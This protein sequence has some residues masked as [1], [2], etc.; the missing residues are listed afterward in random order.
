MI[1]LVRDFRL[2]PVVLL[3]SIALLT[4]KTFGL[5]LDGG[6]ILDTPV[7]DGTTLI[8][9]DTDSNDIVGSIDADKR[10]QP[11]VPSTPPVTAPLMPTPAAVPPPRHS[12]AQEM[13][14]YP[15]VTGS[16]GATKKE[17]PAPEKPK[18]GANNP[19]K[20]PPPKETNVLESR[21]ASPAER[22]ILER[23]Q[24]RRKDLEA[25]AREL[26]MRETLIK[27]AEKRLDSK[28]AELKK[29]EKHID[30]ANGKKDED[31]SARL[32]DL[33]AMY[34]TMKPKDAARIFDRLDMK[35]LVEVA[36]H[37]KPRQMA[38]IMAQ[39][40]PEAAERLTVEFAS[41]NARRSQ[42][43]ADLPKIE[44]QPTKTP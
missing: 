33:V 30:G 28:V 16:V 43:P 23:L 19:A 18:T 40:S 42:S 37:I 17:P 27:A 11:I 31:D 25:R 29:V 26:D 8:A 44:G 1:R 13:F 5:L 34:E 35:V 9:A 32:K 12:W 2:I 41:R 15:D 20:P 14:N 36:S 3:A 24:E 38:E 21:V 4:L 7:A 6:Y 22:A 39:M 10:P